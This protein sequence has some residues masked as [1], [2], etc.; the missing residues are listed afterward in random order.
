MAFLKNKI[1]HIRKQ[2]GISQQELADYLNIERT[3]LSKIENMHYN[4]SARTMSEVANFFNLPIGDIFFNK[5]VSNRD[6][7]EAI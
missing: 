4:P 7:N 5:T 1:K 3:S 2:R 6:T